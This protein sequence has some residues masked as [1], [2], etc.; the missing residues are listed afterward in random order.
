MDAALGC[1]TCPSSWISAGISTGT[2]GCGAVH[3]LVAG[4]RI[5]LP[6]VST[7]ALCHL[8]E[9]SEMSTV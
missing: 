2:D 6:A 4:P 3:G 1:P 5:W 7:A 8:Q 9:Q